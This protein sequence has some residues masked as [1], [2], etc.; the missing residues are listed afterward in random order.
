M[1]SGF[2]TWQTTALIHTTNLW[3][4]SN[5]YSIGDWEELG[6]SFLAE[7]TS[8]LDQPESVLG[9]NV[10]LSSLLSEVSLFRKAWNQEMIEVTLP[11]QLNASITARVLY[12]DVIKALDKANVLK[13]YLKLCPCYE[14][15]KGDDAFT[16]HDKI[17]SIVGSA[18]NQLTGLLGEESAV[19]QE[20]PL[21]YKIL[22]RLLLVPKFAAASRVT[23]FADCELYYM[24]KPHLIQR[25]KGELTESSLKFL[26]IQ[27]EGTVIRQPN[28]KEVK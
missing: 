11:E 21:D 1:K 3:W 12:K 18:V 4:L 28:V 9:E 20:L 26:P 6:E 10:R 5:C 16:V 23:P 8:T 14:R 13:Y 17:I 27:L 15:L 24:T 7:S 19:N 22:F 25:V 2:G